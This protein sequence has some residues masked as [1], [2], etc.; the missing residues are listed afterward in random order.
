MIQAQLHFI[1]SIAD[2]SSLL[3]LGGGT[4]WW[5][6][7][8]LKHK[9]GVHVVFVDIADQMIQLASNRMKGSARVK[10]IEGTVTDIPADLKVDY[11]VTH[12]YLDLIPESQLSQSI[13]E[14]V[15]H[16]KPGG[17]W[18]V[19]DFMPPAKWNHRIISWIMHRFFRIWTRH[20]NSRLINW[21]QSLM[22]N[23]LNLV[24]EAYYF[25]GFIKTG[26]YRY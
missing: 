21:E 2:G 24:S 8:L 5:L 10:F 6:E 4:G 25:D 15:R 19:T 3:I 23:G 18:M 17:R 13:I 9:P 1:P 14:I 16:L 11:V 26:L 22:N 7:E 20:P 12:F